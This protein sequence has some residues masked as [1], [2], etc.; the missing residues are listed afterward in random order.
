MSQ[1][2]NAEGV[3]EE[4][5]E[6]VEVDEEQVDSS[7]PAPTTE[8]AQPAPSAEPTTSSR[9]KRNAR[10]SV[11]YN[12]A[13]YE[14]Q[15]PGM[16]KE[17]E[18]TAATDA[19]AD[20][21]PPK[22]I[23]KRARGGGGDV[24]ARGAKRRKAAPHLEEMVE[25]RD[26]EHVINPMDGSDPV[27]ADD[28]VLQL[29]A[30]TEI[31]QS[32]SAVDD[33]GPPILNMP[34]G[35]DDDRV[36]LLADNADDLGFDDDDDFLD[37]RPPDLE[38]NLPL[39]QRRGRPR[40]PR[41]LGAP[42]MS[43]GQLDVETDDKMKIE[44]IKKMKSGPPSSKIYRVQGERVCSKNLADR[45]YHVKLF[46]DEV[47]MTENGDCYATVISGC[48]AYLLRKERIIELLTSEQEIA[49]I[50][51]GGWLLDK[52]P[53]LPPLVAHKA[54]YA[55]YVDGSKVN[56]V[57][58]VSNDDLKPWS[59]SG[60]ENG[61]EPVI[62]PNVRRHPV[63][64]LSGRL[65]P[66]KGDPRLAELHLTEYSAWLPRQPR[67]RK[68]IFYLS[69]DGLIY[70]NILILYD[71][72]CSGEVPVVVNLP[73]G[74]DYLR[75]AMLESANSEQMGI[76]ID[77]SPGSNPFEEEIVEGARGGAFLKVKPNKLG[78]AHNKKLLL[79]YLINEPA[80]LD[81]SN[82][83]NRRVPYMPPLIQTIGV[84]V[85]FVPA[86]LVANQIHHTGD[87]LS[88]WTVNPHGD[89][90]SPRVRSTRRT[91]SQDE[92]GLLQL[93]KESSGWTN[94]QLCL[95]ETMSVLA[96]CPRLRKRVIYIQRNNSIILGNVCYI[97][98][99]VRE[100]PIPQPITKGETTSKSE[101]GHHV[102][103]PKIQI[104]PW[105]E[106]KKIEPGAPSTSDQQQIEG[107]S[108]DATVGEDD[109]FI[110]VEDLEVVEEEVI[111][112]DPM[113]MNMP[114]HHQIEPMPEQIM[115]DVIMDIPTEDV[116]N[117][118]YD[119]EFDDDPL[120]TQENPAPYYENPR[121]LDTGHIYLTVRHKRIAGTFESVLEWI[122]NTN[123]V[124]ERGLLN[125]AKPGHPPIVRNA[126]AYAFF[127][128]GTAIF[129]HDINRDDFS[130]WSHNGNS[131]NPT[132][133]RT[134]V[135]KVGVVCDEMGS[136]FQIKD[137]DYKACPFHLVFLYSI[138]PREP[139]LRKKIYYMMETESRLVVSHALILYDYN[140]EGNLPRIGG[141]YTKRYAR[142]TAKRPPMQ[143]HDVDNDVSDISESEK[144]CPFGVPPLVCDDGAMYLTLHDMDFWNDRNRQLHY[145]FNKPSLV[146]S[147]GCV[148]N[149]VPSLPPPTT[150]KGAY[151]FFVNGLEIDARNLT[152]DGLVPWSENSTSN[153]HGTTKRP[154]SAKS[155]LA[156]NRDGQLRVWKTPGLRGD[157]VEFQLHVYS[158]TLPRCPR[159]RK[160]VV[161]VLRNG[162]Q[163]G[164]A[165]IIY[166]YT[167]SGDMPTPINMNQLSPE[168]SLQ[169]LPPNIRDDIH[170]LLNR[171][172]PPEV[173]KI[174]LEKYGITVNT[175][176]LY[177]IR[178]RNI[179]SMSGGE[180]H[181]ESYDIKNEMLDQSSYVDE[182][183]QAPDGPST[184][185]RS[186][187][188]TMDEVLVDGDM[189][190][191]HTEEIQPTQRQQPRDREQLHEH[192]EPR[193][194]M[195][196][197]LA[198][199]GLIRG[200]QRNEAIWRIAKNSFGAATENE[201]FDLLFRMLFERNEARLLQIVNQTFGVEIFPG[202]EVIDQ[203]EIMHLGADGDIVEEIVEEEV[204]RGPDD[205]HVGGE[206]KVYLDDKGMSNDMEQVIVEEEVHDHDHD[207]LEQSLVD[208]NIEEIDPTA[209]VLED[210]HQL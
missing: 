190:V 73:H 160:K 187:Q 127:V 44:L 176:M 10:K 39:K 111:G 138:N 47:E 53:R 198:S 80:L 57:K 52:P 112:H 38:M 19:L 68:K 100:G 66:V 143:I 106:R 124:E 32:H 91:L 163:I 136:Q 22:P 75:S 181:P 85:Y 167:E 164:H 15:L 177:Y 35:Y 150:G 209:V 171:L 121:Q 134:K 21:A 128:A 142:R 117:D 185:T 82:C 193:S 168:F 65:Q 59:S 98:E 9:P 151:V 88:P 152:C 141:G 93:T 195:H 2:E 25:R 130:P 139:R 105:M 161:Y 37:G 207:L 149:R 18:N 204:V 67:L 83:L 40:K 6:A 5:Q 115:E 203:G 77:D 29:G 180:I 50:R 71:Y 89:T 12:N 30:E 103:Q 79:K 61:N 45:Q 116:L 16:P 131:Q 90:P 113:H 54:C 159:L 78:W 81:E 189:Q 14:L 206:S 132:C 147:L 20:D 4:A 72:T 28:S 76:D 120:S 183:A 97:Y 99:Y 146:D 43:G 122:A 194:F 158:A 155:A 69:R 156:L 129:P 33:D 140:Q 70:G 169:R 197:K 8:P 101:R 148:N 23:P 27:Y 188:N 104:D 145:L 95:V 191:A 92:H 133:Y 125:Y 137:I 13:D 179:I 48:L 153:T 178:R 162:H 41:D 182:W 166:W 1:S 205:P 51:E 126:R 208:A 94:N 63:A 87:G 192:Q 64:R 201:T 123:V 210:H 7:E 119:I 17:E 49:M 157:I 42:V 144:E 184:S 26:P 36:H 60:S 110:D 173:A 11:L 118:G 186:K 200:A 172:T 46:E 62:K 135:R 114:M 24:V 165:M 107:G 174:V 109:Q 202:E 108:Q 58:E 175:K 74:N 102:P 154:K 3:V 199:S 86:N 170:E 31:A 96:R 196:N 84:Y 55:F 56:S 34:G